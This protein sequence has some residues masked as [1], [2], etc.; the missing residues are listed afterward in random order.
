MI[1]KQVKGGSS[2]VDDTLVLTV[3]SGATLAILLWICIA[4][5][6]IQTDLKEI[7]NTL[8]IIEETL[9]QDGV[10]L[11]SLSKHLKVNCYVGQKQI[12]CP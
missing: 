7:H 10:L 1:S 2:K 5:S 12:E 3:L 11:D 6:D 9:E 4:V 8:D